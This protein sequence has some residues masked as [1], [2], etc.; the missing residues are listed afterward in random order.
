MS[1]T[2]VSDVCFD[3]LGHVVRG[4]FVLLLVY[5][6]RMAG[7]DYLLR[8]A[9][10]VA[11]RLEPTFIVATV[12]RSCIDERYRALLG[13]PPRVVMLYNGSK[14][15]EQVGFFYSSVVD[16]K[17]LARGILYALRRLSFTPS[18]LGVRLDF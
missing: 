2:L 16:A 1:A 7:S 18:Q 11:R 5:D 14:V 8:L 3:E 6:E 9:E 10:R 4:R 12:K 15:W 13:D 17:V